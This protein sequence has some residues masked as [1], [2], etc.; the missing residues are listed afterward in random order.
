MS[1][2]SVGQAQPL[3]LGH[4]ATPSDFKGSEWPEGPGVLLDAGG[5]FPASVGI[6]IRQHSPI[7]HR[8]ASL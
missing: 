1:H 4:T 7:E 8:L 6:Q 3:P 5:G 2:T